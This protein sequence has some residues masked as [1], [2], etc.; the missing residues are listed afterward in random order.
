M[1]L[2]LC[3]THFVTGQGISIG[4]VSIKVPDLSYQFRPYG[5]GLCVAVLLM[6]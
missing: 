1:I 5:N 4:K 6:D 2:V 3:S